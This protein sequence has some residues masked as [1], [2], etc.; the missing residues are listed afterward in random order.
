MTEAPK[1]P[2]SLLD[3]RGGGYDDA[4]CDLLVSEVVV[5]VMQVMVLLSEVVVM[6]VLVVNS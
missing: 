4:G 5:M 6:M 2:H 3:E 1:F